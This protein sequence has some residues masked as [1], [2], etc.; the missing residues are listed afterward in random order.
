MV[1]APMSPAL[2]G[3]SSRRWPRVIGAVGAIVVLAACP[4]GGD[5][6]TGPDVTV[7]SVV[8]S[9]SVQSVE[10]GSTIQFNATARNAS[11][12]TLNGKTFTWT[13]SNTS[14]ATV[15]SSGTVTGVGAGGVTIAA[16]EAE[17]GI[18]GSIAV[19][20]T[21]PPIPVAS[22]TVTASRD[23]L[24]QAGSLQLTATLKD[25][26][27]N[28]LAGRTVSWSS[29]DNALATVS[30]SGVVSGVAAGGPVTITASAEGKQGTKQLVV[31]ARTATRVVAAPRFAMLG[32]AT[33]ST[34]AVSAFDSAG[35]AIPNPVVAWTSVTPAIA[36]VS[37]TGKVSAVAVGTARVVARVNDAVD[38]ATVAVADSTTLVSTAFVG[39]QVAA[40]A[41]PGATITVPV[42]LEMGRVSPTGDLGA[43]QFTLTF[44]AAVLE[45]VSAASPLSGSTSHHVPQPGEFRFSYAGTAAQ[46]KASVTLVTVT[47]K[48]ATNAAVGE[49]RDLALTYT[50]KP[51]STSFKEYAQPLVFSGRI[52]IV[53]P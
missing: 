2:P 38:T 19:T 1:T 8:V 46:N 52:T 5:A 12:T 21:P 26:D 39:G 4:A 24:L 49:R 10:A 40:D 48:V 23:T 27:G 50:A 36:S 47:L 7:A 15:S 30:G 33:D 42:V 25:A 9:G 22:V 29:S 3:S 31:K 35:T 17:S 6:P 28:T 16:K 14:V 53:A 18:S 32:V 45:F 51:A 20:V 44:D 37:V 13:S 34:F 11:G 41:K 43:A